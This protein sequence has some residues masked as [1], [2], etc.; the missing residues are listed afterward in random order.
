MAGRAGVVSGRACLGCAAPLADPFLDLGAQPL[1]N[2]FVRPEDVARPEPRFPLAVA[3]CARCHLVQLTATAPPEALFEEYLY[4]TSYSD[5]FLA[6]ARAM[7]AELVE[8]FALG[9]GRRVLEVASNDGYLLQFFL[10]RGVPVLGVEPARNVAAV[11][12]ARGIPTLN[13][14]FG[15]QAVDEI[16]GGFGR[17]DVIVGNNVLAHVPAING[18]LDAVHACLAPGGA[19][20]FEFPYLGDLLSRTAFDTIYHE[21]VFYYSLASVAGLATRA[22]LEVFDV[23]YQP[24][25]GESLRV[26]VQHAGARPVAPAVERLRR[27]EAAAGLTS[28][29]RYAG[30]SRDVA[31]LCRDL[32]ERLRRLRGQGRRLAAY[33]A[34]A[35]GTVLLNAC[36]IGTDVLEF[37]VDRSPHKQGRLIP[38]VRVPIR[39]VED[40]LREMPDFTL[41]L[42]WNL[43]DE[44]VAQQ[45]EYLHKGGA[46]IVAVPAT[47]VIDAVP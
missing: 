42:P 18:F 7:A 5:H 3:Y 39:P 30:F 14:F 41:L 34:P 22:G 35:K 40:L 26:F 15:P 19:A 31:A 28:A 23:E 10:E 45:G 25:H 4:F 29:A 8:R 27:E 47:R 38:G 44:I 13:R 20:V 6:H 37:T 21:H 43:V 33:G 11:A 2:A 36:G 1:A 46:F 12:T 32:T 24:V 9:P 17:P 16:V